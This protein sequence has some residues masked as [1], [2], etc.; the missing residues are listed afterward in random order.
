MR[1]GRPKAKPKDRNSEQAALPL[2]AAAAGGGAPAAADAVDHQQPFRVERAAENAQRP[3]GGAA[4]AP[5][6]AAPG[7]SDG[8]GSIEEMV[9]R[10]SSGQAGIAAAQSPP[11]APPTAQAED[12]PAQDASDPSWWRHQVMQH[13]NLQQPA[14]SAQPA[15]TP[16]PELVT[17]A[18]PSTTQDP[19]L[20]LFYSDAYGRRLD[21]LPGYPTGQPAPAM[22]PMGMGGAGSG[23]AAIPVA[24]EIGYSMQKIVKETHQLIGKCVHSDAMHAFKAAGAHMH[25]LNYMTGHFLANGADIVQELADSVM[26]YED[27]DVSRFGSDVGKALRK[28]FLSHNSGRNLPEGL[29]GQL[30]IAN[31]TAGML[32]GFFGRGT[33]LDVG[34]A[35]KPGEHVHVDMHNCVSKNLRFFQQIWGTT[36]YLFAQK[37]SG[38]DSMHTAPVGSAKGQFQLGTQLAFSMMEMPQAM[39]KCN[40][41]PEQRSMIMDS[42][43]SFGRGMDLKFGLPDGKVSKQQFTQDFAQTVKDWSDLKWYDFGN[44]LGHLMQESLVSFF[45]QKYNV[46]QDGI[47]RQQLEDAV[48]GGSG[49]T[50]LPA[51]FLVSVVFFLAARA[52]RG[53]RRSVRGGGDLERG[54]LMADEEPCAE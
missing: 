17:T 14:P 38:A 23:M 20:A 18:G 45:P 13:V 12:S 7:I 24:M 10:I 50:L 25:D 43:K 36:M 27:K 22:G 32:T 39:A 52:W 46:G 26:A 29:P 44:G 40:I 3:S 42:V 19:D 28:V 2:D 54:A 11:S 51:C 48:T 15:P 4:A 21:L 31:V 34:F 6:A 16:A 1:R 41:N 35:H 37:A 8:A 47:L 9:S 5:A 33:T 53:A 30:Q 49:A